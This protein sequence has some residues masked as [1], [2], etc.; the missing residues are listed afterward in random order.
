MHRRARL[1]RWFGVGGPGG[2][3]SL[4]APEEKRHSLNEVTTVNKMKRDTICIMTY[5]CRDIGYGVERGT[6]R[7]RWTGEVD[8]WGKL[9]IEVLSGRRRTIYLFANEIRRVRAISRNP[10]SK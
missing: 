7:A 2:K 4:P 3:T 9:T 1:S 6:V 10:S 5:R 8:A